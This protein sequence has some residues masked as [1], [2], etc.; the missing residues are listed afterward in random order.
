M[1]LYNIS[2]ISCTHEQSQRKIGQRNQ[3]MRNQSPDPPKKTMQSQDLSKQQFSPTDNLPSPTPE[4][5]YRYQRL[6]QPARH[7][8]NI[9][10]NS[11]NSN[12]DGQK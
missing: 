12:C 11:H 5:Q 4:S 10:K 1:E 6:D 3:P 2:K 7:Y 9:S 8:S